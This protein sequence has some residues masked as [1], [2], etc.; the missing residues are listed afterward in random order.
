MSKRWYVE[1]TA[2]GRRQFVAVKRSRSYGGHHHHHHVHEIDYIK[3]SREEWNGLVEKERTLTE[4]NQ[5]LV[6]ECHALK[7][8]LAASQSEVQRLNNVACQLQNQNAVLVADNE[9]LRR[10][11]D[12]ASDN[13][14]KHHLEAEKLRCR[15]AKLE[16]ENKEL[17][18]D[19]CDLRGRVKSLA[20]Q[21]EQSCGHRISEMTRD[22]EY[23]KDQVRYWKC[24]YEEWRKRC[25]DTVTILDTR[26]QKMRAYEEILQR[27]G[28]L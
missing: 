17:K 11:L 2:E 3:V 23:W 10:S 24:R 5:S 27:R 14:A 25:D 28:I 12:C 16:K 4:A 19:V 7:S 6:A 15:V 20:K 21:L 9:G 8:S 13:A 26:S 1:T 18:E 22:V